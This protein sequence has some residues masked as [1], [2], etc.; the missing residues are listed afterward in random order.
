MRLDDGVEGAAG[1]ADG[2]VGVAAAVCD[3]REALG[4]LLLPAHGLD[5]QGALE[6]LVGDVGDVGPQLLGPRDPR[7]HD[8][9]EDHV[10]QEERREDEPDEREQEGRRAHRHAAGDEHDDHAEGQGQRREDLKVASMSAL[11]LDSSCPVGWRRC[12]PAAAAGTAG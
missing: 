4:L 12:Q 3:L 9:L 2:D 7:R 5:D 6:G 8:P 10:G 11:A 1:A